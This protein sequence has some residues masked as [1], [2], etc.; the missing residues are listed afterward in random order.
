[1]QCAGMTPFLFV[2]RLA[3]GLGVLGL[4]ANQATV[5]ASEAKQIRI[6]TTND[7]HSY[8]RPI[9]YRYL[10][11]IKPWGPQSREGN[12]VTKAAYEGKIGGMAHVATI[13]KR[14]RSEKQGKTLLLDAGDTW[15]GAG[16]SV[17]DSRT[18][19]GKIPSCLST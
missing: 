4:G 19:N 5:L 7:I 14:L 16:I 1:M 11:E 18:R 12:Y 9:Y 10:D 15:H 6:I 3:V 13:I 8:L 17:F 2:C